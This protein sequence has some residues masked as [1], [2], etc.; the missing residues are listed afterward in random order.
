MLSIINDCA[1]DLPEVITT[2]NENVHNFSAGCLRCY[3]YLDEVLPFKNKL[4]Q[5]NQM[6]SIKIRG[7]RKTFVYV[8]TRVDKKRLN[9][10][11]REGPVYS[12]NKLPLQNQKIF[13]EIAYNLDVVFDPR[14]YKSAKKRHQRIKYPLSWLVKNE[15]TCEE[16]NL[17]N[18]KQIQQL[19]DDWV[20]YKLEQ[21]STYRIMFPTKR[22]IKCCELALENRYGD[23]QSFVFKKR[24]KVLVVRVIYR[25]G[26]NA[27]DLAFFGNAKNAISQLMNYCDVYSLSKLREQE[28]KIFNC[29]AELN[30]NLRVFKQ[31]FPSFK[32]ESYMYTRIT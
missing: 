17:L 14:S 19:H 32:I 1:S 23:L 22:Y 24:D 10:F 13:T 11:Q 6:L 30:K 7:K 25:K 20:H 31:H 26:N 21:E 4:Y 29:G 5:D 9:S 18:F 3:F 8:S 16:I 15:I 28:V 2:Y 27:F 12:L